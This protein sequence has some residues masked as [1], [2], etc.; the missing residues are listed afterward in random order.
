MGVPWTMTW[1]S[2]RPWSSG[3]NAVRMHRMSPLVVGSDQR[4]SDF[5]ALLPH[6]CLLLHDEGPLT[7]PWV[8]WGTVTLPGDQAVRKA[9]TGTHFAPRIPSGARTRA[10]C[11]ASPRFSPALY[12]GLRFPTY[13]R[14]SSCLGYLALAG[15]LGCAPGGRLHGVSEPHGRGSSLSPEAKHHGRLKGSARRRGPPRRR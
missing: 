14:L 15:S 1:V 12:E 2:S 8:S 6:K 4:Q 3:R 13:A 5:P 11:A 9:G 10:G 7:E